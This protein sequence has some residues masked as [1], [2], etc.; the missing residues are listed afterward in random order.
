MYESAPDPEDGVSC[1]MRKAAATSPEAAV[2]SSLYSASTS[3]MPYGSAR[4]GTSQF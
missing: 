4:S 3:G 2:A 1:F